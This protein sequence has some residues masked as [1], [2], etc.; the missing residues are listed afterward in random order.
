MIMRM[1]GDDNGN[2]H[3]EIRLFSMDGYLGTAD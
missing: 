2:D 3:D 1:M